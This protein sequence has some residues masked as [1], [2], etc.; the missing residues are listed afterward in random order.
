MKTVYYLIRKSIVGKE[1]NGTFWLFRNGA[2][3]ID[4]KMVIMDCL[5]GYDPSEGPDSPYAMGNTDIMEEIEKIS[6]EDAVHAVSEQ[7]KRRK[8]K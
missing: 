3:V 7:K 6:E 5:F 2:W 1:E 4:R 8:R